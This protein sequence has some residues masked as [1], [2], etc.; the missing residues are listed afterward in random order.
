MDVK[1]MPGLEQLPFAEVWLREPDEDAWRAASAAAARSGKTGWRFWTT[2][3]T[4]QVV[5]F[6]EARAT[7]SSA[8]I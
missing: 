8:A 2:D 3:E 1:P 6:L 7:R 5:P 4:P